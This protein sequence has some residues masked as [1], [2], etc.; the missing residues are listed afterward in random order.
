LSNRWRNI[1]A[2]FLMDRIS[3]PIGSS[4]VIGGVTPERPLDFNAVT[5]Y[6]S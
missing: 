2:T 5:R 4:P 3:Q 6:R 1:P